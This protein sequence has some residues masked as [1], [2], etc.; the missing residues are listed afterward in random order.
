MADGRASTRFR[1][2]LDPPRLILVLGGGPVTVGG[3]DIRSLLWLLWNN[4]DWF[5][6]RGRVHGVQMLL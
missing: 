6:D 5:G 3:Q 1:R 4:V 2:F